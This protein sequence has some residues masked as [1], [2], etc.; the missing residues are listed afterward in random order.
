MYIFL[1]V[2]HPDFDVHNTIFSKDFLHN[3][4]FLYI[5]HGTVENCL[6][7]GMAFSFLRNF[8]YNS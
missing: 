5:F 4:Y 3:F 1:K 7:L 2:F 8:I 6:F